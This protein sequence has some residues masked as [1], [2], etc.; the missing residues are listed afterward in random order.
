L[1]S[2]VLDTDR[3]QSITIASPSSKRSRTLAHVNLPLALETQRARWST[4]NIPLALRDAPPKGNPR[5]WSS[6]F[7]R[8]SIATRARLPNTLTPMIDPIVLI[9]LIAQNALRLR[10]RPS[11]TPIS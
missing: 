10:R 2:L 5:A 1:V 4:M 3:A 6:P 7:T 8:C 11:V 9:V